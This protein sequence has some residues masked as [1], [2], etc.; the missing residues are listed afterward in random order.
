MVGHRRNIHGPSKALTGRKLWHRAIK[1]LGEGRKGDTGHHGND[2]S[3]QAGSNH[4]HKH[5][6]LFLTNASVKTNQLK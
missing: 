1:R 5:L 6:L 4:F 3:Q 2:R